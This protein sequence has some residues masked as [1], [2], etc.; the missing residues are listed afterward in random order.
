MLSIYMRD[1]A[2]SF[3]M[4]LKEKQEKHFEQLICQGDM[5]RLHL[6]NNSG[7]VVH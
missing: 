4:Y 2:S 6:L 1:D 7:I 5:C 3:P